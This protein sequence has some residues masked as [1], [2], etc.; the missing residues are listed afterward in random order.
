VDSSSL[1]VFRAVARSGSMNRAAVELHTVQ[2]NVTRQ[3][4][5]LEGELGTPLFA[6][7]SRGVELTDA[8][9][10]LLPRLPPILASYTLAHPDVDLTLATNTTAGLVSQVLDHQLHGAFVCGP[11]AH[12]ELEEHE[13]FVER[14]V[15]ATAPR[16]RSVSQ[17]ADDA[18]LRIVVF[19]AGCSY[20]QRLEGF[21]AARGI[22]A[23]RTLEFGTVDG[24][25]GCVAAGIGITLLPWSV[26]GS[27]AA[28]GRVAVHELPPEEAHVATVFVRRKD[29]FLSS[30]LT[31][32]LATAQAH[33]S[34]TAELKLVA[35]RGGEPL[36]A[37][38]L[39]ADAPE[40]AATA[41]PPEA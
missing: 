23:Q 9:H 4:R 26:V 41:S 5:Q 13:I 16:I 40:G 15:L 10:R 12:P 29:R 31:A 7:H 3:V 14:L 19:R 21:L 25:L 36:P 6:R 2:S 24:I 27:A 8:G 39:Q 11:I 28:E 37:A 35:T 22:N 20:R 18:D 17:L 38:Q 34:D 33:H 1:G 30:A 32:F